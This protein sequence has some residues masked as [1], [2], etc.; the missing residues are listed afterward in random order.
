MRFPAVPAVAAATVPENQIKLYKIF[1]TSSL[2]SMQTAIAATRRTS[3]WF[4]E[5][6][7]STTDSLRFRDTRANGT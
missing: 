4:F 1:I 2:F 5:L 6:T 7:A 3:A